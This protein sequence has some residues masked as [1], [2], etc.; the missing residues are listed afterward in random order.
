VGRPR[1]AG[2][3]SAGH[4]ACHDRLLAKVDAGVKADCPVA[5]RM[6]GP[7][8]V[9]DLD[10]LPP[11]AMLLVFVWARTPVTRERRRQEAT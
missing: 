7:G 2:G 8:S 3:E 11:G 9:D 1:V 4:A 10:M 5:G 6:S